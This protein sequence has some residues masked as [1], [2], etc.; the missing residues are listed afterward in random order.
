[1]PTQEPFGP[2]AL[3][4][5]GG[6]YRAAGFHLGVLDMLDRLDLLKDV[7]ALST[8]SGGTFTGMRYAL[9]QRAGEPFCAF[10][11]NFKNDLSSVDIER[12]KGSVLESRQH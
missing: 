4:L 10:F 2:I 3:S 9:S 6:G 7:S 5:S 11:E 12:G 8:V 1:M